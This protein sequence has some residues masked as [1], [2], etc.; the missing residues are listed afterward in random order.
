[1]N[2]AFHGGDLTD[3][4]QKYPDA[5]VPWI[6]LSTGINPRSYAW[7]D[8]ISSHDL[9]EAG[10]H[11]PSQKSE[12]D[13]LKAYAKYLQLSKNIDHI[14]LAPGSQWFIE[15]LPREIT[16][17]AV[18]ILHPTYT[19][20]ARQWYDKGHHVR[21]FTD[22]NNLPE[23]TANS[24]LIIT[25]PNN[26]DGRSFEADLINSLTNRFKYIIIDEAFADLA[27]SLSFISDNTPENVIILRSFGKFFGLAGI[28]LGLL[29]GPP[30]LIQKLQA[31]KNLWDISGPSLLIAK[32][33][34]EDHEWVQQN[35]QIL[36]DQMGQL[37]KILVDFGFEIVGKTNLF[38]L[39][40]HKHADYIVDQLARL[41]I[42]VRIFPDHPSWIRFGLPAEEHWPRLM[43]AFERI[44]HDL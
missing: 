2:K 30:S 9:L 39:T 40:Y 33:A 28:R 5:P 25:N 42:Y 37:H 38:C 31:Q 43:K 1:M 22:I 16:T 27:P 29:Y 14:I 41:G 7:V 44:K 32:T 6:D 17:D 15:K 35:H 11:L 21:R 8:K 19:E 24:T 13:C 10:Q 20:H 4:Q 18:Y 36:Q 3:I 26:P 23:N 12:Q 34:L